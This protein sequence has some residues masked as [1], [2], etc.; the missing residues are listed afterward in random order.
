MKKKYAFAAFYPVL[1]NTSGSSEVSGSFFKYWP[2]NN[3]KFF[4]ITHLKEKNTN[5]KFHSIK[6]VREKPFFKIIS[7]SFLCFAIIKFLKNSREPYL[8]VEGPSW[9][10]YS[11][12]TIIIIKFFVPKVKVVYHSHSIEFEIRKKFNNKIISY[13]TYFCEKKVF[14]LSNF[15]TSVSETEYK[16][17]YSLYKKKTIIFENGIDLDNIKKIKKKKINY[18]YIIYTGS[19]LYK[20]NKEAIDILIKYIMPK[21]LNKNPKIKLI[22]TGGGYKQN[23][24]NSWLINKGKVK[25]KKLY[26]Y[27]KHAECLVTPLLYG[28]GTRVKIIE[29]LCIGTKIITTSI[30]INGINFLKKKNNNI[31]IIDDLKLFPIAVNRLLKNKNSQNHNKDVL[32]YRN[33]FSMNNLTKKFYKKIIN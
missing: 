11:Y 13:L 19:Y 12:L 2:S 32:F 15:S 27:L 26:Y 20:P 10:L 6:I 17:I 9:I 21:I 22:I 33:K 29:S 16:K 14:N 1:P 24:R 31:F 30:G 4:Y 25:K 8:I 3:K 5:N 18:K 7:L 28:S 23:Q